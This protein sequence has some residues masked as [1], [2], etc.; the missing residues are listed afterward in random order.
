MSAK[1]AGCFTLYI[2]S[3]LCKKCLI[4]IIFKC[5]RYEKALKEIDGMKGSLTFAGDVAR[6]A[7]NQKENKFNMVKLIKCDGCGMLRRWI[8]F[9]C[10]DICPCLIDSENQELDNDR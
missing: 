1:C 3:P 10:I 6:Q 2:D 9:D 5:D 7:I 4:E 8:G